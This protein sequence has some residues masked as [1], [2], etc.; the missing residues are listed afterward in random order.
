MEK[1]NKKKQDESVVGI[2]QRKVRAS[3]KNRI[4]LFMVPLLVACLL[5]VPSSLALKPTD[6]PDDAVRVPL[7]GGG[8]IYAKVTEAKVSTYQGASFLFNLEYW[9]DTTQPIAE[10]ASLSLAFSTDFFAGAIQEVFWQNNYHI[11]DH[12]IDEVNGLLRSL[13]FVFGTTRP[14]FA[15]EHATHGSLS[16]QY[17]VDP[18]APPGQKSP[19]ITVVTDDD[20]IPLYDKELEVLPVPKSP[21]YDFTAIDKALAFVGKTNPQNDSYQAGATDTQDW[22][23]ELTKDYV[24]TKGDSD[25]VAYSIDVNTGSGAHW[26]ANV[27]DYD[28]IEIVETLPEGLELFTPAEIVGLKTRLGNTGGMVGRFSPAWY[29]ETVRSDYPL[30]LGFTRPNDFGPGRAYYVLDPT[31]PNDYE[32]DNLSIDYDAQT[33]KLTIRLRPDPASQKLNAYHS[34]TRHMQNKDGVNI[35]LFLK[36]NPANG[37]IQ[38]NNHVCAI[39]TKDGTQRID[40]RDHGLYFLGD[41]SSQFFQ[42]KVGLTLDDIALYGPTSPLFI[43]PDLIDENGRV[44]L[45][46][47]IE[48]LIAGVEAPARSITILDHLPPQCVSAAWV[49]GL[50]YTSSHV[51]VAPTQ[52]SGAP[53]G[54]VVTISNESRIALGGNGMPTLL[55][56]TFEVVFDMSGVQPGE[57]VRNVAT[58]D[59]ITS[60]PSVV[61]PPAEIG[62]QKM[63]EG[64]MPATGDTFVFEILRYHPESDDYIP[65][66]SDYVDYRYRYTLDDGNGFRAVGILLGQ[67]RYKIV[68]TAYDTKRFEALPPVYFE[69][70]AAGKLQYSDT[71]PS[72]ELE[73]YAMRGAP[74]EI[75]PYG[76]VFVVDNTLLPKV[77]APVT[78]MIPVTKSV[79]AQAPVADFVFTLTQVADATGAP[80]TEEGKLSV[81]KLPISGNGTDSFEVPDLLEGIYY[82]EVKETQGGI[83]AQWKN[84]EQVR[85]VTVTVEDDPLK[86]SV[87]YTSGNQVFVNTYTAPPEEPKKPEDPKKPDKPKEPGDSNKPPTQTGKPPTTGSGDPSHPGS[88][89][90]TPGTSSSGGPTTGSSSNP[91]VRK[92]TDALP[93]MG[94]TGM[95]VLWI[96]ALGGV[97]ISSVLALRKRPRRSR[98]NDS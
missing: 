55:K 96:A 60:P 5:S 2:K 7:E 87:E 93:D 61:M 14:D 19:E 72:V 37:F 24:F 16:F 68:E 4:L 97:V 11:K 39:Y 59:G 42:K 88:G 86:A 58:K 28:E 54:I 67:G 65:F 17:L 64:Q 23:A 84:D 47:T 44:T 80:Y 10:N 38:Y 32:N 46:Y 95:M 1:L 53:G 81:M 63:V 79:N 30:A 75:N 43:D 77:P 8:V 98:S 21:D 45:Y 18:N 6:A 73:Y 29:S 41:A 69:I 83:G 90:G 48:Y 22:S 62:I 36:R 25:L 56:A 31:I 26:N 20:P 12:R 92:V 27:R 34:T 51:D 52:I 13:T 50:P 3:L 74:E 57:D 15:I 91:K 89:T 66:T 35:M 70:D 94:D 49:E 76:G 78:A 82:F 9:V 71:I 33:R 85:I 40:E